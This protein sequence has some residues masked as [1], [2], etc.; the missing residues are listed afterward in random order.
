MDNYN[1][2]Q[3]TST[4][5]YFYT[6]LL[7]QMFLKKFLFLLKQIPNDYR[8]LEYAE[9]FKLLAYLGKINVILLIV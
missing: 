5:V 3:Y 8:C 9:M 7:S 4:S 1:V 2:Q 6:E